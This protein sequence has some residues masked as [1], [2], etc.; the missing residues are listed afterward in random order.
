MNNLPVTEMLP[1]I[2]HLIATDNRQLAPPDIAELN[3]SNFAFDVV[4]FVPTDLH[5][6]AEVF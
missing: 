1:S 5:Q 3:A 2:A 4:P 6:L